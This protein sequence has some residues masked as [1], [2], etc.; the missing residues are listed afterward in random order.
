MLSFMIGG[1]VFILLAAFAGTYIAY[2]GPSIADRIVAL[3]MISTKVIVIIV[4][5]AVVTEQGTYVN[6]ALVYAMIGF[7][8]TV[9]ATKYLLRGKLD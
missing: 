4:L 9:G 5:V 1:I 8:T 2:K 3:N 6:V 7:L